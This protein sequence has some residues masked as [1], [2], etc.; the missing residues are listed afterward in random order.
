MVIH[1]AS[2]SEWLEASAGEIFRPDSQ[3]PVEQYVCFQ[4]YLFASLLKLHG[5]VCLE[6]RLSCIDGHRSSG[7]PLPVKTL[8]TF[9]T[10]T[11]SVEKSLCPGAL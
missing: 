8:S 4:E 6:G 10:D 9:D 11:V 5:L 1:C 7:F 3:K 2:K